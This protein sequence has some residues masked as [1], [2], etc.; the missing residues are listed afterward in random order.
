MNPKSRKHTALGLCVAAFITGA[1]L[2][3]VS[4]YESR[5]QEDLAFHQ[6]LS[7]ASENRVSAVRRELEANLVALHALRAYL[8]ISPMNEASFSG[9]AA[10]LIAT[11]SSVR[12]LEW[13]PRVERQDRDR[14]ERGLGGRFIFEGDPAKHRRAP[15]RPFYL[16]VQFVYP[17][18][19]KSVIVGFDVNAS[20]GCRRALALAQKTGEPALTEKYPVVEQTADGY[21]VIALMPVYRRVGGDGEPVL[22]GFAASVTQVPDVVE[23]G[24]RRISPRGLDLYVFD[25]SAPPAKQLLYYHPSPSGSKRGAVAS[26]PLL[27]NTIHDQ[28]LVSVG[29]RDWSFVF[30]PTPEY[31]GGAHSWRSWIL[32]GIGSLLTI[33]VVLY[34]L[35][36]VSHTT[37]TLGLLSSLENVNRQLAAARDEALEAS[38][39]KSQFL[40]TMSH[41]IRTPMNGILATTELVLDTGLTYEQREL[42]S[43]CNV[44]GQQ[45][46]AILNDIL[47]LSRC[48]S[49]KLILEQVPFDLHSEVAGLMKLYNVIAQQKGLALNL[50]WSDDAQQWVRGD[51]TRLRQVLAN[52]LSNALKFTDLGSVSLTVSNDGD[53]PAQ[54]GSHPKARMRFIIEDTGVGM[55]PEILPH[56]FSPFVQGEGSTTRRYGGSGLGLAICKQLIALMGG[57]ID[58]ESVLGKGSRFVV[59]VELERADPLRQIPDPAVH[60][61]SLPKRL[62]VLV[63]ED[64][65]VNQLVA[66]RLLE[67]H[68]CSVD[69]VATGTAAVLRHQVE[70]YDLILMDCQMPELDGYEAARLIRTVNHLD[71]VPIIALTAQAFPGDRERCL[72]AGMDDYVSKPIN[73]AQFIATVRRWIP[74]D[75][76]TADA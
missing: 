29:G 48:E 20:A 25:R 23:S 76:E 21:G 42:I 28:I 35:L 33:A 17:M 26:E 72:A 58:V 32:L 69:V 64:N 74:C 8:E 19:Q 27:A 75:V 31:L 1:L 9:F 18:F 73:A 4:F 34:L 66:Q 37:R 39:S 63:A 46:L 10:R 45:L 44:S 56:L 2:T 30:V 67:R 60:P 22:A 70:K 11:H 3:G 47:D 52:L 5:R 51:P 50:H 16:P 71:R 54:A 68:G 62:H 61:A 36:H 57:A 65:P 49:G 24:L 43:A 6:D 15:D 40:A 41:E 13:M 14:F 7:V 53:H 55:P 59:Q 12:S 38:R